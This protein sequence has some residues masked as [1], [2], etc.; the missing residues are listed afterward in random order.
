M[1]IITKEV[2]EIEIDLTRIRSVA[3]DSGKWGVNGPARIYVEKQ[4]ADGH[5]YVDTYIVPV[6]VSA[7]IDSG[8]NR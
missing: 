6:G 3:K 7:F 4:A 2:H 1:D 5:A 8:V